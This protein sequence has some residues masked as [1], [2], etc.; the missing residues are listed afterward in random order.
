MDVAAVD[1]TEQVGDGSS[2]AIVDGGF[3]VEAGELCCCWFWLLLSSPL[4]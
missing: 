4:L 3:A 2:D 1:V